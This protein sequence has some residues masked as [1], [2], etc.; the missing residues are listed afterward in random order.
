MKG[1]EE[2]ALN[3]ELTQHARDML[4]ERQ[5]TVEWMDQALANPELTERSATDS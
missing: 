5:I 1:I 2:I 3:Y 4:E